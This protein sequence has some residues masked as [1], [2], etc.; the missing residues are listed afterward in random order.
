[1]G[2]HKHNPTVKLAEEGKLPPKERRLSKR[3]REALID[4]AI[5]KAM[6]KYLRRV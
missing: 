3:E 1:M 2:A 5:G 4:Q 6:L